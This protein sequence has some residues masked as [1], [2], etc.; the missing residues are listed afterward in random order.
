[1][2]AAG[3]F[4]LVVGNPPWVRLHNIPAAAR[5][6]LRERFTV[7][8]EAPWHPASDGAEPSRRFGL[9]ID[10]AALFVERGIAVAAPQGTLALLLPTK[11]W[12]SLAG[13]PVRRLLGDAT[14]LRRLED[15]TDAPSAFDAAVYP[16][17]VIATRGATHAPQDTVFAVR[18]RTL[19]LT[20][21]GSF[22]A[23]RLDATDSA[24]PWLLLPPDAR[25]AF[26]LLA[27]RGRPLGGQA[28]GRATLGVKCGCNDAFTVD[29]LDDVADPAPVRHLGREGAIERAL[30]RPLLRG[31]EVTAWRIPT[32][33]HAIVWTHHLDGRP[34]T[35]LPAGAARWLAP[36]R[37]RLLSRTDLRGANA[38]WMLFRTE[39]AECDRPRVV[40]SDF[41]RTPRAAYLPPGEPT[42]PLNSC[43]VLPCPDVIDALAFTALL[44]SPIASA[45]L[46]AVAEPA[47]G[48]WHRYLAWTVSLLPLPRDWSRSRGELAPLTE[49]ALLGHPPS[50]EELI[51]ATC[52]AYRVRRDDVAPLVAW[53]R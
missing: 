42:V 13:G 53:C 20:W 45:W 22:A 30:L 5:V 48:G 15:W 24:S 39:A 27:A 46:N 12:R 47:R 8:R 37:R 32:A 35:A 51:V 7:F 9:Q 2:H 6:T 52:R 4:G 17:L 31:E 36:W 50:D 18:R 14:L 1:V 25:A 34:L 28:L 41:G 26:D 16:S 19:G 29:V 40:W 10:L 38:W 11:L 44:N 21:T 23:A 43:Y 33:R 49:R 3:G